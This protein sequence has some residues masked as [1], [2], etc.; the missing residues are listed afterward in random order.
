MLVKLNIIQETEKAYKL[1][2]NG[3]IPKSVLDNRGLKHP[4]YQIKGWWLQNLVEKLYE[5]ES[6]IQEKETLTSLSKCTIKLRDLSK[7]D[8]NFWQKY[9]DD[10]YNSLPP[11]RSERTTPKHKSKR[12]N[13]L[14]HWNDIGAMN[15]LSFQDLY[16]DF[17]Y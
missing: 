9:W 2:G 16:G 10:A 5:N 3:W 13:N 7:E 12:N 15:D 11:L 4:Y 17:G 6:T 1:K 8:L 14:E